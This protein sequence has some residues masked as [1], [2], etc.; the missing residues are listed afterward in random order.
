[1]SGAR[2]KITPRQL[3]ARVRDVMA[4]AGT[5]Q[6]RLNRMVSLIA[7]GM[8][9][10]V[11]SIYIRRAGDVLELFA[12]EGLKQTAVHQTRLRV[13]EGLVGVIAAR[14]R[15]LALSDAQHHPAFVFR[16]ETGEEIYHSLMG[17]PI[18]RG[19][20]VLGVLVVQNRTRRRYVAEEV[21]ILQTIAMVL[22]EMIAGGELVGGDELAPAD[23]IA[24]APLQ[25]SGARFHRGMGWAG[26]DGAPARAGQ[27]P[28]RRG[29]RGGTRP[30]AS[31]V[32]E[33]HGAIDDLLNNEDLTNGSEHRGI[34]E[35]YRMIAEDAAGWGASAKP[36]TGADRRSRRHEGCRT[37]S[38]RAQP[39]DGR[40]SANACTTSTTW[41]SA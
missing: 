33:M 11:C 35:S 22:A 7:G 31:G 4:G 10:E 18:L 3:L 12:T 9:A 32:A 29:Y 25:I 27:P 2:S 5:G 28:G 14:T 16:P 19:G 24:V 6:D 41:P 1:M 21:E 15:P 26:G 23:G 39:G 38:G 8:Q 17:V 40:S 34:L 13:G 37:T 30:A 20:R 36:S